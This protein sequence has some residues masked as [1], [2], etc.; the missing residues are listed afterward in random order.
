MTISRAAKYI[1]E[2]RSVRR[3]IWAD[4]RTIVKLGTNGHVQGVDG[5]GMLFE[6]I[7]LADDI[8]SKDWIVVPRSRTK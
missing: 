5:K 7:P 2:G 6:Y 8:L 4:W 3:R 1:K